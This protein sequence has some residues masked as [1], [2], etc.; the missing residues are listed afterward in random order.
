MADKIEQ[1]PHQFTE[2]LLPDIL[3]KIKAPYM[4]DVIPEI[5]SA[6]E[7]EAADG[8][9]FEIAGEVEG[10]RRT[11]DEEIFVV[12]ACP[13]IRKRGV[14]L[15]CGRCSGLETLQMFSLDS[16]TYENAILDLRLNM[17]VY[18]YLQISSSFHGVI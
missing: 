5:W 14:F 16:R 4:D 6:A 7:L 9:L 17:G 13:F 8:V 12:V 3:E 18:R 11:S 2:K 10:G 15:Y 1:P